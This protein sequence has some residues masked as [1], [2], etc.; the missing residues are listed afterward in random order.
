MA[1]TQDR[2]TYRHDQVLTVLYHALRRKLDDMKSRK[3][4]QPV[5]TPVRFH[6]AGQRAPRAIRSTRVSMLET[7]N[8]WRMSCDLSI[9][10]DYA[11]P[12][13]AAVTTRRPDVV[14]WSEATKQLVMLELTVPNETRVVNA[15]QLKQ[16]RYHEL[17]NECRATFKTT[18]LTAEVGTRGFLASRTQ[19]AL[20]QLGIWSGKLHSDLSSAALRASYAIYINR[21]NPVWVW[22]APVQQA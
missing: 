13:T 11:F 18:V 8:D 7:A 20:Q 16:A 4:R 15:M 2:Y 5:Q 9:A 1:L 12:I 21:N 10:G 14:L 6:R 19:Q 3:A 17:A 22:D